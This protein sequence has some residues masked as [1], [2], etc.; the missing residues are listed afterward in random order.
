MSQ[1]VTHNRFGQRHAGRRAA[2]F[3]LI[4]LLVTVAIAGI[5]FAAMVPLFVGAEEQ[6]TGDQMRVQALSVAQDRLEK[7]RALPYDQITTANLNSSTFMNGEFGNSW[8]AYS[9]SSQRAFPSGVSYGVTTQNGGSGIGQEV[10]TVSVTWTPPPGPV[11]T[12]VV[13][14]YISQRYAGPALTAFTLSPLDGAGNIDGQ[15][16]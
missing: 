15:A 6:A 9:G 11:K 2:G 8:T 16:P 10:V 1:R 4:E 5:A 3:T 13:Q 7:I 14:T 12:V